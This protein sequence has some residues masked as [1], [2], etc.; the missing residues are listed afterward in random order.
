MPTHTESAQSFRKK[1]I[2]FTDG[3][4]DKRPLTSLMSD[5]ASRNAAVSLI[6]STIRHRNC[7]DAKTA[8]AL[9]GSDDIKKHAF[10]VVLEV[11]QV[12]R[13]VGEVVPDPGL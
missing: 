11:C 4:C 2:D 3:S 12:I 13:E 5:S 7:V 6:E 10:V 1:T 8:L 9:L